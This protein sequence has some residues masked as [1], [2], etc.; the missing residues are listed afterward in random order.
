METAPENIQ[1]LLIADVALFEA[2]QGQAGG[3]HGG[4][5]VMGHH[6]QLPLLKLQ[7][8][9]Q[10]FILL[11]QHQKL[12]FQLQGPGAIAAIL[13]RGGNHR[14]GQAVQVLHLAPARQPGAHLAQHGDA[15]EHLTWCG[16]KLNQCRGGHQLVQLQQLRA[17]PRIN[18]PEVDI[19]LAVVIMQEC[20]QPTQIPCG[21]MVLTGHQQEGDADAGLLVGCS[22]TTH[23]SMSQRCPHPNSFLKET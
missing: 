2:L 9:N 7:A 5:Q 18:D 1:K 13:C 23:P 21:Q 15:R 11:A 17:L 6:A 12:V 19:Q 14:H 10:G 22:G 16:G 20:H 4:A 3:G 8:V